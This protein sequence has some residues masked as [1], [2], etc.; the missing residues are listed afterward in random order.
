MQSIIKK[1]FIKFKRVFY[2]FTPNKLAKATKEFKN[3]K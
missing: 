3:F 2:K 1:G